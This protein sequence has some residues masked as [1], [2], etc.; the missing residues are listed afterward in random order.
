VADPGAQASADT[1]PTGEP[2]QFAR[3]RRGAACVVA[4]P[5]PKDEAAHGIAYLWFDGS[6]P[7]AWDCWSV[8]IKEV[9][10]GFLFV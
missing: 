8:M 1:D 2:A 9:V 3:W 5:C 10:L 7:A 6:R 4:V